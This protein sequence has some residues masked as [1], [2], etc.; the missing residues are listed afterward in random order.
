MKTI[1]QLTPI[2]Q[3]A[4]DWVKENIN[5]EPWQKMGEAICIEHGFIEVVVEGMLNDELK[6]EKDFYL[7]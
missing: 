5:Y 7:T 3:E 4:K 1:Y 2:S 6:I